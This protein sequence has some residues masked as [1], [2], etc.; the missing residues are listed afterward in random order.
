MPGPGDFGFEVYR[1]E[2]F[3]ATSR[4]ARIGGTRRY[5]IEAKKG[6]RGVSLRVLPYK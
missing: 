3:L 4:V 5:V 6:G 2:L 1:G